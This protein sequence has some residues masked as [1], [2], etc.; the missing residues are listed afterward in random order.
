MVT[1]PIPGVYRLTFA[2]WLRFPDDGRLYEILEGELYVTPRPSVEHQ[3]ISRNI[4]FF[5]VSFL[6][7]SSRGE[8]LDAPIGVRLSDEDV[9]E[10]DLVVVLREHANRIG[11]Q[12]IEGVPDLIVEILSPGTARRDLGP[13]R[14]KYREAGV[15]EYW[16]VDPASAT[17]DVQVLRDGA[18]VRE[19]LFRREETLRSPLLPGLEIALGE[20]F[21]K[22]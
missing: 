18:Y 13:K 3:R 2:D 15:P 5:L 14:D 21:A 7:R 17:I 16:I 22:G 8:V 1:S 10:P 9:L 11:T 6:R 20:V 12:V 19:A 4:E